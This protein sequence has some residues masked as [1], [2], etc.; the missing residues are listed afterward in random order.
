MKNHCNLVATCIRPE[1]IMLSYDALIRAFGQA[2][3]E[4]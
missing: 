1:A 2:I 4:G 3:N